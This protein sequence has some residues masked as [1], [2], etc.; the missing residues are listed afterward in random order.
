MT[1]F[2]K[3]FEVRRKN[4]DK[5]FNIYISQFRGTFHF[6][7]YFLTFLFISWIS[8][9]Q[10]EILE[11]IVFTLFWEGILW[12]F[13]SFSINIGFLSIDK[14]KLFIYFIFEGTPIFEPKKGDYSFYFWLKKNKNWTPCLWRCLIKQDQSIKR[15]KKLSR[16]RQ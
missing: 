6:S 3:K 14:I 12:K 4:V 16:Q 2:S 11:N 13:I 10:K 5:I 1:R 8:K 15:R 9:K 7:K